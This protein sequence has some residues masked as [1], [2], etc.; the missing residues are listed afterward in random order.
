MLPFSLLLSCSDYKYPE[1][2]SISENNGAL[3]DSVVSYLPASIES[4]GVMHNF[5]WDSQTQET[6]D[7]YFTLT[8]EPLLYNYYLG[9][10]VY[11]FLVEKE[12]KSPLIISINTE[13]GK[14]WVVSKRIMD[15]EHI[16]PACGIMTTLE[17]N[18]FS[19]EL[20]AEDV[21]KLQECLKKIN[22]YQLSTVS[23]SKREKE[24]CLLEAHDKGKYWVVYR[25]LQDQEIK[26]LI[27]FI[28]TLTR[29]N[30]DMDRVI[31]LPSD[32]IIG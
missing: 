17:F 21:V 22:L 14:S 7:A 16:A 29:F 15:V 13:G 23:P 28:V 2:K 9:R 12:G 30:L 25:S 18:H 5:D 32:I 19:R 1:N 4:A 8:S 11:R 31:P 24:Y 6:V 3:T 10:Q 26:E 20:S 27:D